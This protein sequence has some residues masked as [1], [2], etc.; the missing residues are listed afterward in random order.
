MQRRT[1]LVRAPA[2]GALR[3]ILCVLL[4]AAAPAAGAADCWIHCVSG[5]C[6]PTTNRTSCEAL[7][8]ATGTLQ[9]RYR[10]R[11][12]P[13]V[14]TVDDQHRAEDVLKKFPP[15]PCSLGDAD[16]Q[17]KTQEARAAV[18][19]GHG[20]DGRAGQPGGRGR[21]CAL[22][23]PCGEVVV[24]ERVWTLRLKDDTF[25]GTWRV[26]IVRSP[27][28]E[29]WTDRDLPVADGRTAV[30]AGLFKPGTLYAYRLLKAPGGEIASGEFQTIGTSPAG[31]V[32]QE[33]AQA[34]GPDKLDAWLK[35][36][37]ENELEWNVLQLLASGGGETP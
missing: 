29:T 9:V 30:P 3:P 33:A 31:A 8:K 11:N 6:T 4:V 5:A 13:F 28:G 18:S 35:T 22:W 19:G 15:D 16:C 32:R 23:L 17:Q 26:S 25:A 20:A 34:A 10:Y 36:L 7:A 37:T 21:P 12:V 2:P 24:P 14:I 27:T 1:T